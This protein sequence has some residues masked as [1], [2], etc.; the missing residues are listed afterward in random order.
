MR[1]L[2][3]LLA[4]ST[5]LAAPP[6]DCQTV[7]RDLNSQAKGKLNSSELVEVLGALNTNARLPERFI[8]KKTA[9]ELGWRPGRSLWAT[10]ALQGKSLGG[11]VFRNLERQLPEGNWREADLNYQG[12]KRG[13][14]RL[15]FEPR[16]DGRRFITTDH[17]NHFMEA[18]ACR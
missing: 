8:T 6:P 7:V 17:Y 5:L 4:S 16:A 14:Q 15:V 12:G 9:R 2:F 10:P 13:A 18:P 11:D 3:A 1:F